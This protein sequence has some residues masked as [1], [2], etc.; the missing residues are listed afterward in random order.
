MPST[1]VTLT[2]QGIH[3]TVGLESIAMFGS[4]GLFAV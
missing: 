1:F 2:S 4:L 3:D